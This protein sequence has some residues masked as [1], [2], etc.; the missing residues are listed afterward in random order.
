MALDQRE[1]KKSSN[2]KKLNK[3]QFSST[4]VQKKRIHFSTI[5]QEITL[6]VLLLQKKMNIKNYKNKLS[7]KKS[8]SC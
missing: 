6:K 1:Q 8:Q 5:C 4:G 2:R 3:H 7:S